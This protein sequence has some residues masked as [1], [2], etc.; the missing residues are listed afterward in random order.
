MKLKDI[1]IGYSYRHKDSPRYCWAEVVKVLL[2]KESE[3]TTSRT[4]V[5]CKWSQEKNGNFGLIKYFRPSDLVVP[6]D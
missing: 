2:P 4:I 6:I 1:K 3:N 5:K